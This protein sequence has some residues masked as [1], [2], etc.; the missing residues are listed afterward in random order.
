MWNQDSNNGGTFEGHTS[1]S[2]TFQYYSDNGGNEWD[3]QVQSQMSGSLD[4][5]R[6]RERGTVQPSF[7][8]NDPSLFSHSHHLMDREPPS[9]SGS[10]NS[11]QFGLPENFYHDHPSLNN[12]GTDDFAYRTSSVAS[13]SS[14]NNSSRYLYDRLS[15][16]HSPALEALSQN[17]AA[18]IQSFDNGMSGIGASLHSQGGDMRGA[19]S[20]LHSRHARRLYVG[21][22]P[23]NQTSE[24]ML[25]HFLNEVCSKC[26]EEEND[27]SY[28][29]SVYMNHKKCFAFV[30]L[31]SIELTSVCLE[32][33]GIVYC[34]NILKIQR[35][36]EYKPELMVNVPRTPIHFNLKK[37]PFPTKAMSN[38]IMMD[39]KPPMHGL[40]DDHIGNQ[41]Y[42]P[43]SVSS[44]NNSSDNDRRGSMFN[45]P[46]SFSSSIIRSCSVVEI[47]RGSL[48]LVGFPYDEGARRASQSTGA[49]AGPRAARMHLYGMM[50]GGG[51]G[52]T[53]NPEFGVDWNNIDMQICDIG[54]IA[55]G[56][57]LEDALSRLG[58]SV[59]EIIRRGGVPLVLGGSGDMSYA[60]AAGLMTV[61]GGSIGI[62]SINSH[63][64]V[65]PQR[66]ETKIQATSASRL[67]LSDTRFCPPREGL[68]SEPWC[69]GKFVHIAAQGSLCSAED[70]NFV[71]E[72][73]GKIVWLSKDIRQVNPFTLS[74]LASATNGKEQC[75][76]L[77]KHGSELPPAL[78]SSSLFQFTGQHCPSCHPADRLATL[79]EPVLSQLKGT[80]RKRPIYVSLH[81]E[82]IHDTIVSG[83]SSRS[84]DG[85]SSQEATQVCLMAGA[86]DNV[87]VFDICGLN[88][89]V[90]ESK[91]PM[92]VAQLAYSFILGF[93]KRRQNNVGTEQR[94]PSPSRSDGLSN[95]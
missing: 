48:V 25:Q 12:N 69:D 19:G 60:N 35:A 89:D 27:S 13:N 45:F 33:D 71:E 81:M 43:H 20:T 84:Y 38:N 83:V 57:L 14:V 92:F 3:P 11:A 36:N 78:S 95:I 40:H 4:R 58:D 28:V 86:D 41:E 88:P 31:K 1:D 87:A 29:I 46:N 5:V 37:A 68:M 55:L 53:V 82:A 65:V 62:V 80:S 24:E 2:S 18:R 26:M 52:G 76:Q 66:L 63:L 85:L 74:S 91:S 10:H 8:S 15:H 22:I 9:L 72:R 51:A 30:E 73:G 42:S 56:L 61:A 49:S 23:Q 16:D 79:L 34:S 54:D 93:V 7:D 47:P 39:K 21:G 50:G 67:L 32:L 64:N 75:D 17:T 94:R 59:A 70:V 6:D 90:E 77:V 44:R